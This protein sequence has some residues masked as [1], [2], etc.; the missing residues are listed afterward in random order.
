MYRWVV[1]DVRW[2]WYCW[3]P[4]CLRSSRRRIGV[5]KYACVG[6]RAC[7][8]ACVRVC[9]RGRVCVCVCARVR[10]YG[11]VRA[12]VCVFVCVC[13][14]VCVCVWCTC[15][16]KATNCYCTVLQWT[17]F[18]SKHGCHHQV[19]ISYREYKYRKMHLITG[20]WAMLA[21]TNRPNV[22]SN[23]YNLYA[24]DWSDDGLNFFGRNTWVT[25]VKPA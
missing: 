2:C 13:V 6:A 25:T 17:C 5:C 20:Q 11:Y 8:S 16:N 1:L 9:V 18:D 14:C 10:V 7:V 24:K 23:I 21:V 4:I 15:R 3:R 22:S 12:C 19:S